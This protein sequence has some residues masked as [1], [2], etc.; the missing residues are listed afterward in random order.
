MKKIIF[1]I[2][3]IAHLVS[4]GNDFETV[5]PNTEAE[6]NNI[7]IT[8]EGDETTR[9][10]SRA[11][12]TAE[13]W[14]KSL[15][16]LSIFTFSSSDA[17]VLRRD[18][19]ASELAAKTASFALP[20]S[21]AGTSCSF[22]A[23]ANFSANSITS[24]SALL[25]LLERSAS[26]YNGTI[27]EVGSKCNRGQGFVMSGQT[28]QAVG[29][30]N[31]T[32]AIAITL[33]RT[34]AKLIVETYIDNG[35]GDKYSGKLLVKS[36]KLS[37]AA[38]QSQVVAG[39]PNCGPMSYTHTQNSAANGST[40]NNM[41]FIYENGIL[42]SGSRV[43]LEI[44]ATYDIDGSS[45]TTNDISDVKYTVELLGRSAGQILRNGY[46]KVN[47]NI[48]GLVGQNCTVSISVADWES[49]ITQTVDLGL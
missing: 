39:S 20:K 46:Y 19:T 1:A 6:G 10:S 13:T 43:L 12:G 16:S 3:T 33:K 35:F 48:T 4:C 41:F 18:F 5:T 27:A 25:A 9:L 44:N 40:Y 30:V 49:P 32:T 38:S 22:Y 11:A 14:E 17:L 34:V 31:S 28:T 8:L 29:A 37:K 7:T 47:A 24:K 26:E 21:T 15:T 42:T 45:S 36:I 2:M 23:V